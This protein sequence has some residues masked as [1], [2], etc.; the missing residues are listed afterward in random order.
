MGYLCRIRP[1]PLGAGGLEDRRKPLEGRVGE[2]R[3]QA[4]VADQPCAGC[5]MAVE[6]RA[7]RCLRVVHVQAAEPV[8]PDPGVD[9]GDRG[10]KDLPVR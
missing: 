10:A 4:V 1:V 3:A 9:V 6:V 5:L 7:E 2:E 8:E